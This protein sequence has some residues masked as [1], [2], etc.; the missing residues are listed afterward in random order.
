MKTLHRLIILVKCV[1]S[2][3]LRDR[4][5]TKIK[6]RRDNVLNGGVNCIPFPF[7]R[8]REDVPGLEQG[9]YYLITGATKSSKSQWAS[10][11]L[12]T[13]LLYAYEHPDQLDLKI[14]YYPLEETQE[15][16][17][18][19]FMSFLLYKFTNKEIRISPSDLNSINESKPLPQQILDIIETDDSFKD[20]IKYF[21][22]HIIFSNTVSPTGITIECKRYAEQNGIVHRKTKKYR[23]ENGQL[24]ETDAGFDYYESNNPKEYRIIFIDH[25]SLVQEKGMDLRQAMGELSSNLAKLR[26][27]YN[28]SP[29]VVQQQA[30]FEN[31]DAYKLDKLEPT[32]AN[33]GDNKA[34]SRDVNMCISLFSPYKYNIA[35]YENYNIGVLKDNIRFI[36][37]LL[38][39]DGICNG[40]LP[41]YFDGAVNYFKPMPAP[42]NPKM[43]EIYNDITKI[44]N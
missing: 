9:K 31:L 22:D 40:V 33:L 13:S 34:T 24:V 1:M 11:W 36:K 6:E 29:I 42:D 32:I 16:I 4:V 39:R 20:L 14:L 41:V 12:F 7:K 26:N 23:D 10:Y 15:A 38:N 21:E 2:E 44:R 19:R 37:V 43:Q 27:R 35:N 3:T 28:F 5:L 17:M 18:L 8:F 30:L 25:L